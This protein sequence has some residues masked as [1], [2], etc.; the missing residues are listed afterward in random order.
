METLQRTANRGSVATGYVVG[1]SLKVES[2]NNEYLE[3][4]TSGAS[5]GN[6]TQHTISVWVKRTQVGVDSEPV[7]AGGIGRFRFESDDTFSYQFRS[8]K[9][10]SLIHI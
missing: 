2:D 10:L 5:D 1:N 4:S 3:R 6:S 8:G 9:E 7:S